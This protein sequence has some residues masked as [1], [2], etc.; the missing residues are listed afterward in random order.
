MVF[1]AEGKAVLWKAANR[2]SSPAAEAHEGSL[3]SVNGIL[4]WVNALIYSFTAPPSLTFWETLFNLEEWNR[5]LVPLTAA[6]FLHDGSPK[7]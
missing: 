5:A 6:Y 2:A 1:G 3:P 4:G 7:I